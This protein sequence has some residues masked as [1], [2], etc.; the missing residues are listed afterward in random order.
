MKFSTFNLTSRTQD[1]FLVYNSLSGALLAFE[2]PHS[3]LM[4]VAFQEAKASKIPDNFLSALKE[5]GFLVEN[6]A[7]ELD[8]I[9]ALTARR[10]HWEESW[11][12]SIMLNQACNFRCPYC[13]QPRKNL[14][15]SD[16][17][18]DVVLRMIE[19][20]ASQ[21]KKI[22]VDWY[23]GEPTLSFE[24]L[25]R[26]N[27][28]IAARCS[29]AGVEYVVSMTTNGYLLD[30]KVLA[31]LKSFQTSHLQVTL[32]A[33]RENHNRN[34]IPPSGEPTFD[35]ILANIKNAA[36]AG[37]HVFV[38]VNVTTQNLDSSFEIYQLLE[39]AGLKNKV[40]VSI[41][42]VVSSEA[43]PCAGNCLGPVRFGKKMTSHYYEAA[44]RGWI[45]LP[46]VD[47]L[48]SMGYCIADYPTHAIVDP[49]GNVYK[50]GEAF[51][52]TEKTGR[53]ASDG[54]I[55]W[56]QAGFDAFVL[57]DPLDFP[58]CRTCQIL[59]ICMGGCHML[60]FW[61]HRTSCN[62][63]KHNLPLFVETLYL[64][65]LNMGGGDGA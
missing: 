56:D 45:V 54:R 40:E 59:P 7:D 26:L 41:R 48:Q 53:I 12:L 1:K 18:G 5:G 15:M 34:R 63:F 35:V 17:V 52:E 44:K 46:F 6:E 49:E 62:E 61:K 21:T 51:S 43:N 20:I 33:P 36:L 58:E 30:G 37:F 25:K 32:D 22:S 29:R 55:L 60:R 19:R 39:E 9:R 47:N 23:G 11:H 10:I 8:T 2:Q 42:P 3:D 31:Y 38:R 57:R 28:G 27:N 4:S 50:C 24:L 16:S 64:N 13:F 65:Q 14:F